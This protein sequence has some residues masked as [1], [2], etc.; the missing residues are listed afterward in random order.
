ML[1]WTLIVFIYVFIHAYSNQVILNFQYMDEFREDMLPEIYL[2][3]IVHATSWADNNC[4]GLACDTLY[5]VNLFH[6]RFHTLKGKNGIFI[7]SLC[8][9]SACMSRAFFSGTRKMS[10]DTAVYATL[11]T[12]DRNSFIH[13][14]FALLHLNLIVS[15]FIFP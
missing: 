9:L 1:R 7:G 5:F 14:T 6:I 10:K 11:S 13:L 15:N 4:P 3:L 8:C 2:R 12:R